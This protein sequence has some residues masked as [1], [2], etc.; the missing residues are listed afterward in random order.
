MCEIV[1]VISVPERDLQSESDVD[2]SSHRGLEVIYD[3][4]EEV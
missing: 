2:E 1:K 4:F 3:Y